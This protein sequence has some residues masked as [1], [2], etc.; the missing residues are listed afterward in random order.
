MLKE[1][2]ER[3]RKVEFPFETC[4]QACP[5]DGIELEM[6]RKKDISTNRIRDSPVAPD[7]ATSSEATVTPEACG[8]SPN[9]SIRRQESAEKYDACSETDRDV[10]GDDEVEEETEDDV[11]EADDSDNADQYEEH[12]DDDSFTASDAK[13]ASET[14]RHGRRKDRRQI[15]VSLRGTGSTAPESTADEVVP[16][17]A[18]SCSVVGTSK[19][20][21]KE[22]SAHQVKERNWSCGKCGKKGFEFFVEAM[23]HEAMCLGL[24]S[25]A[26]GP[27]TPLQ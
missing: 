22:T 8:S 16:D 13:G 17:G 12:G 25:L 24:Q 4:Q 9:Y 21:N 5:L 14:T 15:T 20:P 6:G 23:N 18:V 11:T 7:I 2:F 3:L 19:S 26:I 1:R 10:P 27:V